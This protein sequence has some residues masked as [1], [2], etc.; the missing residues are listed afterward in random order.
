M[1]K[2]ATRPR[3]TVADLQ[4]FRL[5]HRFFSHRSVA[6]LL[7][8]VAAGA[9]LTATG[10][11]APQHSQ[12]Q[13]IA[14]T[15]AV[16]G[17]SGSGDA[18]F[19][20]PSDNGVSGV[21]R[22]GAP[23]V[24]AQQLRVA[25]AVGILRSE[26][27]T[28]SARVARLQRGTVLTV[29]DQQ[30]QWYRVQTPS[31]S[32]GWVAA[33]VVEVLSTQADTTPVSTQATSTVIAMS[34]AF[35]QSIAQIARKY[36]GYPYRYGGAGPSSFDCS[37]LTRYVYSRM[38]LALPHQALAQWEMN[39]TRIPQIA[40]LQP[41]DLVFFANT[42]GRGITHAAIYVGNGLIVTANT[43]RMGVQLSRISDSYWR[44]HWA[45]GLRLQS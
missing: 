9:T 34:T 23:L 29:T 41:G 35:G 26:P 17:T 22:F 21:E 36:V 42:A 13:P 14:A 11:L 18:A 20:V 40:S 3:R 33:E 37:G 19:T 45:G 28:D 25:V 12:A 43:P 6:R 1:L 4:T 7:T 44:A 30:D 24:G 39:G 27:A 15:L 16:L 32:S 2:L 8:A 10:L 38:G 5:N 31:G